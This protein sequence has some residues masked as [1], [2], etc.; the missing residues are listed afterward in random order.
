MAIHTLNQS[1]DNPFITS[2]KLHIFKEI[3]RHKES[4]STHLQ[5]QLYQQHHSAFLWRT[6]TTHCHDF[7]LLNRLNKLNRIRG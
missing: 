7:P 6:T 4:T 5:P 1:E 2:F 3:P